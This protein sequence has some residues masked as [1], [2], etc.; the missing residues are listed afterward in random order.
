[1]S[2]TSGTNDSGSGEPGSGSAGIT[3]V[4]NSDGLAGDRGAAQFGDISFSTSHKQSLGYIKIAIKK[5][6]S[7]ET[8]MVDRHMTPVRAAGLNAR[9]SSWR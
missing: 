9:A 4:G 2:W 1:M 3:M 6:P 8:E 7:Q 5:M